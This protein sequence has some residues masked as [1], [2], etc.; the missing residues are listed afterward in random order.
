M[1]DRENRKTHFIHDNSGELKWFDYESAGI[2]GV[3]TVPFSPDMNAYAERFIG[4]IRREFL[5]HII[6]F[7][8]R[9]LHRLVKEYIHYYNSL[10]PHQGI[11]NNIPEGSP[12][13]NEGEI[14]SRPDSSVC[15][16]TITVRLLKGYFT[17]H[18]VLIFCSPGELGPCDF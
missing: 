14:V 17:F 3:A 18:S 8:Y 6:V 12:P 1:Y 13:Q 16:V 2:K 10:R 5:D 9:Q 4:S 15:T 11:E 7:T